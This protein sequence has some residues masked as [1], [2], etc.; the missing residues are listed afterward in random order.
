[1]LDG[2]F[3]NVATYCRFGAA[4][5][6]ASSP[7]EGPSPPESIVGSQLRSSF[8]LTCGRGRS[9]KEIAVSDSPSTL[10]PRPSLEQHRKQAKDRTRA[11]PGETLSGAQFALARD[12]GF[13]SWPK[14]VHHVEALASPEVQQQEQLARDMAA[15]Y[16]TGDEDAARR[17]NDLFH[18]VLSIDQ[19]R[20]FIGDRLFHVPGGRDRLAQFGVADARLLVARLYGF[21][22]WDAF[23]SS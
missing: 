18:S 5:Q 14:L 4:H 12:Y 10:P 8:S 11:A 15:A 22:D 1:M 13:E 23:V 20:R 21:E 2:S 16:R 6:D 17:L 19:I 3:A 7:R 9:R